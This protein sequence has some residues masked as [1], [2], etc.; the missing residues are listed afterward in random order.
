MQHLGNLLVQFAMGEQSAGNVHRDERQRDPGLLPLAHLS[1]GLGHDP[2]IDLGDQPGALGD[3]DEFGRRDQTTHRMFPAYQRF[4]PDQATG[5]QVVHRLVVDPQLL[6]GE[7][8][9]QFEGNLDP[10]LRVS[11]QFFGVQGIAV[12]P[13]TLGLEQGRVGIAQQLPGAEGVAGKQADTDTGV[14]EQGMT[15]EPQWFLQGVENALGQDR[16]LPRLRTVFHQHGKF[17]AAQAGQGHPRH[18]ELLE[19]LGHAFEQLVA[20]RVSEAVIDV[21]EMVQVHQQQGA[22]ALV[23]LRRGQGLFRAVGK[24]HAVGQ[25]GQRIV[26]GQVRQ[27]VLRILDRTDVG[28]HCNVLADLAVVVDERPDRLPLREDLTTFASIPDFPAPFAPPVQGSKHVAVEIRPVATGLEQVGAPAQHLVPVITGNRHEGP[29][30]VHDQSAAIR[31]QYPF[32]GAIEDGGGL[33]Q[34]LAI[35]CVLPFAGPWRP[36]PREKDQPGA[37]QQPGIAVDQLPGLPGGGLIEETA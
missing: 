5:R 2:A 18:E 9:T 19:P 13:G 35:A 28:E 25:A 37:D 21:L 7:G 23:Q 6:L 4:D 16:C 24:Q 14:D 36:R 12:T 20:H 1:A 31:H 29:V 26:M 11:S 3:G 30:H 8:T 27:F 32:A 34:T 22:A 10:L 33:A 15:V 17:I